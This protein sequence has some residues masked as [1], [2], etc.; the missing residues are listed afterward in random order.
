MQHLRWLESAAKCSGR[1][2]KSI[3]QKSKQF[4]AQE[5]KLNH[6]L[7]LAE[8]TRIFRLFLTHTLIFKQLI[9]FL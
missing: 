3:R 5:N 1:V 4:A 8:E 9:S 7:A 2:R 6:R